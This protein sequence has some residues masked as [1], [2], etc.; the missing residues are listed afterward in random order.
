[1]QQLL[2]SNR[3]VSEQDNEVTKQDNA[4]NNIC[5]LQI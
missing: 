4:D 3:I 5:I 1:M 2:E